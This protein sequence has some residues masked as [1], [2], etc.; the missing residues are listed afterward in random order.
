MTPKYIVT[1]ADGTLG[2]TFKRKAEQFPGEWRFYNKL[3]LDI[4]NPDAISRVVSANS[5]DVV[6]NCAACNDVDGEDKQLD[7]VNNRGVRNLVDACASYRARL[8]HFS[9]NYVYGEGE[10]FTE[11]SEPNPWNAYAKSKLDG[12][13]HVLALNIGS[14]GGLVL[15]TSWIFGYPGAKNDI[16]RRLARVNEYAVACDQEANPTFA[17]CLV[18]WTMALLAKRETGI[19]NAANTGSCARVEFAREVASALARLG[20]TTKIL[21]GNSSGRPA[22]CTLNISKLH[23][24]LGG[25]NFH[26]SNYI[27]EALTGTTTYWTRVRPDLPTLF[28]DSRGSSSE[29]LRIEPSCCKPPVMAYASWTK[30]GVVRGPHQHLFQS[31]WLVVAGGSFEI[32]TWSPETPGAACNGQWARLDRGSVYVPAGDVHAYKNISDGDALMLVLP[33]AYYKGYDRKEEEDI[34]K[35]ENRLDSPYQLPDFSA[36]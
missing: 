30:P 23:A 24:A 18:D 10:D 6:I 11:E 26:F 1:G 14:G 16:V 12:E 13:R 9:T 5:P 33:D 31:E 25:Y 35:W 29:L 32:Y 3:E 17:G 22:R 2:Q 36:V 21:S 28:S 34:V 20:G 8:V 27:D 15:R 4:T 7:A 19:F